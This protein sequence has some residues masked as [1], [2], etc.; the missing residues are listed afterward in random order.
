MHHYEVAKAT[1]FGR[2]DLF[3]SSTKGRH[4]A[5]SAGER[6]PFILTGIERITDSMDAT[7]KLLCKEK[8][9]LHCRVLKKMRCSSTNSRRKSRNGSQTNGRVSKMLGYIHMHKK[10]QKNIRLVYPVEGNSREISLLWENIV[11]KNSKRIR[12]S[13]F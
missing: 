13:E 2:I 5:T 6:L 7:M 3:S 1:R 11:P 12:D 8:L 4:S 10:K 9:M